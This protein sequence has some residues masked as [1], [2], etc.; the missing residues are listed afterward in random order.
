MVECFV[1]LLYVKKST[2]IVK[3]FEENKL[4]TAENAE[5]MIEKSLG[6]IEYR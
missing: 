4:I 5:S 2:E 1:D 6:L 3:I